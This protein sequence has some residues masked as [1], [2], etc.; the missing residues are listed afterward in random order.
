MVCE[1][2]FVLKIMQVVLKFK[3]NSR[4]FEIADDVELLGVYNS[5]RFF[6]V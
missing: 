3:W 4:V 6:F 2:F 5:I 1:I